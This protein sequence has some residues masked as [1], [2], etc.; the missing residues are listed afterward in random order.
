MDGELGVES[1]GAL[2]VGG[3]A[4]GYHAARAKEVG[5]GKLWLPGQLSYWQPLINH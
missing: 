4:P 2:H 1:A 3:G 5:S